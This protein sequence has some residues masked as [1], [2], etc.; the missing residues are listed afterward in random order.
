MQWTM[1]TLYWLCLAARPNVR[2]ILYSGGMTWP[3][4][5]MQSLREVLMHLGNR[6]VEN[7]VVAVKR[8]AEG[9]PGLSGRTRRS[10][11]ISY[12]ESGACYL[13]VI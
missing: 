9:Q 1:V 3:T 6:L 4:K 7:G 12:S 13:L 11:L 2:D 8:V 10:F 5:K